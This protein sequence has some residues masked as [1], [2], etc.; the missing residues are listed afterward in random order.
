MQPIF[1]SKHLPY[2]LDEEAITAIEKVKAAEKSI[3]GAIIIV[4][5]KNGSV[6]YMSE[7][8]TNYLGI[9]SEELQQMGVEYHERFFNP[10]DD[11]LPKILDLVER[12]D[13]DYLVSVLQ[14]VRCSPQHDWAWFLTTT[15][16]FYR[17]ASGLPLLT[18]AVA[19]PVDA[20]HHI[21]AKAEKL[22]QENNFLRKN[23]AVFNTLTKREKEVLR[24]MALG[25]SAGKIAEALFIS[26]ETAN[27]HRRNIK[28]K[29]KVETSYDITRYAQAFDLV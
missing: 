7:W 26:E 5:V 1:Q 4:H 18:I 23:H 9:S 17:D 15:K 13:D 6:V 19:L 16:V 12:N 10:E 27:T 2:A 28:R 29:L 8:G 21:A 25:H 14:Q 22:L 24:S 20:Q 11:Y 3:P